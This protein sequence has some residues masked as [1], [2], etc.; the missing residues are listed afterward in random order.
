MPV[1]RKRILRSKRRKISVKRRRKS[2]RKAHLSGGSGWNSEWGKEPRT[3][4]ECISKMESLNK[5][6][7]S[8]AGQFHS[9]HTSSQMQ[10]SSNSVRRDLESVN[11]QLK[12]LE[13]NSCDTFKTT[14]ETI[15]SF[16]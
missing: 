2:K 4:A 14:I 16:F 11:L 8:L 13:E 7:T 3:K 5:R 12:Y 1:N 10:S 15:Q 9:Q 6:R